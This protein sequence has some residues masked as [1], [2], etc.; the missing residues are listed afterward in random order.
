[1][2]EQYEHSIAE[3][4]RFNIKSVLS[5]PHIEQFQ[6]IRPI[7]DIELIVNYIDSIYN[8][9]LP[10][11]YNWFAINIRELNTMMTNII[12]GNLNPAMVQSY[13]HRFQEM[14]TQLET[15]VNQNASSLNLSSSLIL[16]DQK[17]KI[18]LVISGLNQQLSAIQ[19]E[20][21][22]IS[23]KQPEEVSKDVEAIRELKSDLD[24]EV[25]LFRQ[26]YNE[27]IP[28]LESI[29]QMDFYNTTS[30]SSQKSA[31]SILI[32]IVCIVVG[33]LAASY[34]TYY[35]TEQMVLKSFDGSVNQSCKECSLRIMDYSFIFAIS[36]RIFLIVIFLAVVAFLFKNYRAEMHNK[37]INTYKSNSF[38]AFLVLQDKLKDSDQQNILTLGIY[39]IFKENNTGYEHVKNIDSSEN[40]LSHMINQ[41][42]NKKDVS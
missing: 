22:S 7:K 26:R 13:L 20:V 28:K 10:I 8:S 25:E 36:L 5:S 15:Y 21:K 1:M 12:H 11:D 39:S 27:I 31:K 14:R 30:A 35:W 6:P 17:N 29:T 24:K 2:K 38:Y 40:F 9:S 33:F 18:D 37:T 3:L 42:Q 4:R 32:W 34:S 41:A 23:K 19:K 16:P